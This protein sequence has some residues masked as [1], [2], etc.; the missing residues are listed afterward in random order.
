MNA[1]Y[2]QRRKRRKRA[3]RKRGKVRGRG[4]G[5]GGGG[6]EGE[7]SGMQALEEE[8][9]CHE[10]QCSRRCLGFELGS[11]WGTIVQPAAGTL[12]KCLFTQNHKPIFLYYSL[13]G[14][15]FKLK[16]SQYGTELPALYLSCFSLQCR[17]CPP[18]GNHPI[19]SVIKQPQSLTG[20]NIS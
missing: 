13:K 9:L 5:G 19:A 17:S 4:K 15:A 7:R 11:L 3:R 16:R 14:I 6:R 2:K 20:T 1:G 12:S 10:R 18:R 8:D